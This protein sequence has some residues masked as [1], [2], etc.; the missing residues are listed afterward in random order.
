[1]GA[2]SSISRWRSDKILDFEVDLL[3][4]MIVDL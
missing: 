4:L 3:L 2:V 1:V